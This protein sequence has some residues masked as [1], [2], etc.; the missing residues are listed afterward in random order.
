MQTRFSLGALILIATLS[1]STG[2]Y[3]LA[4]CPDNSSGT[5]LRGWANQSYQAD[6]N[7]C[8]PDV[9]AQFDALK[10][11]GEIMGFKDGGSRIN[12]PPLDN[13]LDHWQGVQ[14]LAFPP[15][16]R[17]LMALT[18][19]H[20]SGGHYALV[21]LG[22]RSVG[23]FSG[24]R[25]GGNRMKDT[26]QDWNV[27][28]QANDTIVQNG[29]TTNSKIFNHPSGIQTLGQYLA[30][31]Q[32]LIGGG[33]PPG[34]T[35][36]FDTG[37]SIDFGVTQCTG[38]TAGCIQSKWVFEH[39]QSGAGEAALAKLD[40]G[41]YLMITAIATNTSR[42][43]INV[44][45]YNDGVPTISN[46][47]V[48]GASNS[49][50]SGGAPSAIFRMDRLPIW[51][52]YQSLQLVTECGSGHLYLIGIEK[53][54]SSE[55]FADLYRLNLAVTG[56]DNIENEP[57]IST[58]SIATTF[59]PIRFKHFWCTYEGS[60]RQCD[61]D[62]AS[63]I[64]VDP[65]GT[66]ILYATVH[67]DS[68]PKAGVTRFIEFAPND[69]V[70]QPDTP[71]VEPCDS[72]SKMWV[73]LSNKP[74][75]TG[76]LPPIGAERFFIEHQNE[77]RS[78]ASFDTAYSFNDEALSIRYCLP[79]GFRYKACSNSAFAGT[80]RFFCGDSV[81]GCSGLISG[82]QVRGAN[83]TTATASSGCFTTSTS[84]SCL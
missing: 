53:N 84:P 40:D 29:R 59:T 78:D 50:G 61:F 15:A 37:V 76:N 27:A 21:S 69:P 72:A 26:T 48:F 20:G 83:F 34:R 44:S 56:T 68:G 14:R 35:E 67:D 12:Y 73:E 65:L 36:L 32:E 60:P 33:G 25:F 62:A 13:N 4:T 5:C 38:T 43:E 46:P 54:D 66:L 10:D 63:G 28:P 70:D 74:L 75:S 6:S 51:K 42:L 52:P 47:G 55:D 17:I 11:H 39:S 57:L 79:A 80:C 49:P 22:T 41:R 31:S 16:N 24:R 77:L 45:Q 82:G 81:A 64:Y 30:V 7:R 9:I 8:V 18:S 1:G 2:A 3:S 71:A 58:A 19:S 23:G